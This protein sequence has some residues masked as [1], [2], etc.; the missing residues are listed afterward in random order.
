MTRIVSTC[1]AALLLTACASSPQ[2]FDGV[3]GYELNPSDTALGITYME[4][5][6]HGREQ[7]LSRI[8]EV[9]S[10][11]TG[12]MVLSGN[13]DITSELS[14]TRHLSVEVLVP[15][16]VEASHGKSFPGE[17][18]PAATLERQNIMQEIRFR[19]ISA[20]CPVG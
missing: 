11:Q 14:K 13:L 6:S 5:A 8:A 18:Y 4:E 12:S 7:T 16:T 1:A 2:P 9:C 19:K 10:Q 15:V 17:G 3:R 20:N